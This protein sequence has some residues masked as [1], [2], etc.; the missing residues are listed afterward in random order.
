MR[1]STTINVR[2]PFEE[3]PQECC[4]LLCWRA[5]RLGQAFPNN[6]SLSFF[7]QI[8]KLIQIPCSIETSV[9]NSNSN[10]LIMAYCKIQFPHLVTG[11][12]HELSLQEN[13]NLHSMALSLIRYSLIIH[14]PIYNPLQDL[15]NM[16]LIHALD[17]SMAHI[18]SIKSVFLTKQYVQLFSL[19]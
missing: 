14:S 9:P 7:Q 8:T 5:L 2:Q 10:F 13:M 6:Y 4:R 19:S 12:S 11:K 17:N 3:T 1:G 15:C 18:E 16:I